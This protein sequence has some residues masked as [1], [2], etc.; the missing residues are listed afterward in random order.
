[1]PFDRL[2]CMAAALACT[3]AASATDPD[4]AAP[5]TIDALGNAGRYVSL[6][7]NPA[8]GQ[9]AVSYYS[10]TDLGTLRFAEFDGNTW[11]ATSVTTFV[12]VTDVFTSLAFVG[13]RPAIAYY[14]YQRGR[15][16]YASRDAAGAWQIVTVDGSD[17]GP[18]T[19]IGADCSLA[20]LP[21]GEP[22]IAYVDRLA[23]ALKYASRSAGVWGK[24]AIPNAT[25]QVGGKCSLAIIGGQPAISFVRNGRLAYA[26][27]DGTLW[28]VST[29][30]DSSAAPASTA[31]VSV[32]GSPVIAYAD[33]LSGRLLC[34][35]HAGG[36][37]ALPTNWRRTTVDATP[38]A[39]MVR[40][41]LGPDGAPIFAYHR[42]GSGG[43]VWLARA[44]DVVYP[45]WM[46]T[47]VETPDTRGA[48]LSLAYVTGTLACTY[49]ESVFA[50]LLFSTLL[51]DTN[52]NQIPDD[53]EPAGPL[54]ACCI[55]ATCAVGGA[56]ECTAAG[57]VYVGD[58]T[59]CT[60]TLCAGPTGACCD[61]GTCIELT[62][63]GC[64]ASGGTY[65][66]DGTV[67]NAGLCA[68]ATGA[69]CDGETCLE[70]TAAACTAAG[71]AYLGDGATCNAGL[72]A[73]ATGA[74]CDGAT[75]LGV[76]SAACALLGGTYLG[77]GTSCAG[78]PCAGPSGACCLDGTCVVATQAA[79]DAA[80]RSYRGD[81]TTCPV[82][83][84]GDTDCDGDVDFED[85]D[86][87]LLAF[88]GAAVYNDPVTGFPCC[89]WLNGDANGDLTVDFFDIDAFI[90][91]L[92]NICP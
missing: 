75:C 5:A 82:T 80:G 77:D 56:T 52:N 20:V 90:G 74:C 89:P 61:G 8:T 3:L 66:G 26:Q 67:C 7:P 24:A 54:G 12:G 76:T 51:V 45:L 50:D 30:L 36:S 65:L 35:R 49:Y 29:A 17:S 59:A 6:A 38:A 58:G 73:G 92:G 25:T 19:Q 15:L 37:V 81:G 87:F 32:G 64:A 22:A 70:V 60:G 44:A 18:V 68:G 21:S 85:I 1:M 9:P 31:L 91:L 27:F 16:R 88:Q 23:G 14:D 40:A 53:L 71:G 34:A 28:T 47:S 43:G 84:T 63:T 10:D 46:R 11:S 48:H 69:C 2:T 13:G 42:T 78:D 57:G 83:C 72:C 55:G 86:S 39:T 41:V 33:S 79:C 4:W 62:S